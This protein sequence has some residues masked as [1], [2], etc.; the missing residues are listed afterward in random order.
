MQYKYADENS[1]LAAFISTFHTIV[2]TRVVAKSVGMVFQWAPW[3]VFVQDL[4]ML[5]EEGTTMGCRTAWVRR[6]LVPALQAQQ[7]LQS[8]DG[9]DKSRAKCALDKLQQLRNA[10]DALLDLCTAWLV[11]RFLTEPA[12]AT[13]PSKYAGLVAGMPTEAFDAMDRGQG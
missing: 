10:D 4:T 2:A 1:P 9:D 11:N 13:A 5:F 12:Q 6:V 7:C 8:S 3:T